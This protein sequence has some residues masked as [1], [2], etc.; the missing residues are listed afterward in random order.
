MNSGVGQGQSGGRQ[1]LSLLAIALGVHP[2]IFFAS[3]F[4][5]SFGQ[6]ELGYAGGLLGEAVRTVRCETLDLQVPAEAEIILEGELVPG[7]HLEPEGPFGEVTGTYPELGQAHVFRLKAITRR[8]D[9]IFYALHCGFPVTDTQST[10]GLGI[11]I[12]TLEQLRNVDGGLDLL[13]V[14]C[15]TVS[16]LMMLVIKLLLEPFKLLTLV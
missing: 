11:E 12:A 6:D 10:T 16:G 8:K 5:T 9:A 14:R 4:S 7:N 2:A 15:L 13:D 1:L 3:G